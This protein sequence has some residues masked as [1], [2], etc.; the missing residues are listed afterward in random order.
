M[1]GEEKQEIIYIGVFFKK[2]GFEW[3]EKMK[4]IIEERGKNM[5]RPSEIIIMSAC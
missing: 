1:N 4:V 3:K 2:F 5:E